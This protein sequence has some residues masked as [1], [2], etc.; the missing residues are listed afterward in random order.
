MTTVTVPVI[1]TDS[2]LSEAIARIE[3][4]W[5]STKGTVRGDE[6]DTLMVLV[7]AYETEHYAIPAPTPVQAVEGLMD[8]LNLGQKD[9]IPC[10]GSAARVSEFL[11]GKRSLSKSQMIALHRTYGISYDVLIDDAE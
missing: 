9:L 3:T 11:A 10:F 4:L 7:N 2:D 1:R 5:G 8:R 6:L